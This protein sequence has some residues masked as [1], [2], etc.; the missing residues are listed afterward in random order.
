M[1]ILLFVLLL[2]IFACTQTANEDTANNLDLGNVRTFQQ[3]GKTVVTAEERVA[4]IA[5]LSKAV[6]N[7]EVND[8]GIKL[9]MEEPDYALLLS[10]RE[11][12]E[13]LSIWVEG[14]RVLFKAKWYTLAKEDVDTL[15]E[16]LG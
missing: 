6:Y 8:S 4:L 13:V 2:P 1:R 11:A 3:I 15:V 7:S 14:G 5:V 10:Y 16:I 12:S 9:K